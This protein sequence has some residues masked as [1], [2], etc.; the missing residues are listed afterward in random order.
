MLPRGKILLIANPVSQSGE[1]ASAAQ[2]VAA[3]L[4]AL[5]GADALDV[6]ST[7]YAGHA[8]DIACN[9]EESYGTVVALGGDGVIH[10]VI[11]GLMAKPASKRPVLGIVP[12]GSGNDYA[13]SLG[14]P[15]DLSQAALRL[16]RGN[17][18]FVDIGCVNGEYFMETLSFGLDAGIALSTMDLRKKRS[19]SGFPLYLEAGFNQL[20]HHLEVFDYRVKALGIQ[21]KQ[22][23]RRLS[24][25]VDI[26]QGEKGEGAE[27]SRTDYRN[28]TLEDQAF[29]F[30][31]NLGPTYGGGFRVAPKASLHDGLFDICIAHPPLSVPFASMV[32]LMAKSG[33]HVGFKQIESF[34]AQ[35]LEISFGRDLPIQVDG[36]P[37]P[38]ADT[39]KVDM[40]PSALEVVFG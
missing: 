2:T 11:N 30:A 33:N 18:K 5:L 12:V 29:L 24:A 40:I 9:V 17:R 8:R 21:G 32:F 16:V 14:M 27:P 38:M 22:R 20:F 19:Y 7:Q 25:V 3:E 39:Y 34:Q 35:G 13:Q 26:V 1:G 37:L 23:N 4:R 36:E 31:V 28:V 10:E 15:E 6:V